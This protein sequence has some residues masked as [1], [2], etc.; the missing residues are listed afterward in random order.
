MK[1]TR[2]LLPKPDKHNF[3]VLAQAV[4]GGG[5]LFFCS[6]I[7]LISDH[8]LGIGAAGMALGTTKLSE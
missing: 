8:F 5:L 2:T 1:A 6:S 4:L 3:I 7:S